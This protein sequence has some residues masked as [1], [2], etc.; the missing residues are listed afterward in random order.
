MGAYSQRLIE[1]RVQ[2]AANQFPLAG[3]AFYQGATLLARSGSDGRFAFLSEKDSLPVRVEFL[4]YKSIE[5]NILPS[6]DFLALGLEP[7]GHSLGEVTISAFNSGKS[8]LDQAGSISVIR[9][10]DLRRDNPVSI[11]N[12]LNRVPGLFMHSGTW[13]THRITIRGI[14]SRSPFGTNK[15][16]AY[17]AEIPLTSGEG[18]TVI[19]DLDLSNLGRVEV[20]RGPASSLYGSGLGGTI[21][22]APRAPVSGEIS[23]EVSGLAGSFG[24]LRSTGRYSS[25]TGRAASDLAYHYTRSEGFRENNQFR[26]YGFATLRQLSTSYGSFTLLMNATHVDALIPSSIDSAS[27]ASDPSAAAPT[28][29]KT[30]GGEDYSRFLL[31]ASYRYEISR[32]WEGASAVFVGFRTAQETRPF[33]FLRESTYWAGGRSYFTWKGPLFGRPLRG[34]LG[35]ELY[36]DW[37]NGSL[38]ANVG[39]TGQRGGILGDNFE[40]R[41]YINAY[42]QAVWELSE[43]SSLSAGLNGNYTYYR[44]QDFFRTDSTNR[45]GRY[46]FQP[47]LSPRL[48]L[49][50]RL[51]ES[52]SLHATLSHGFS[53]PTLAETLT[54][55]GQINPDIQPETG[56]NLEAG[57]RGE[58]AGG[59]LWLDLTA[60]HMPVR[61]LLVAERTQDD[62]LIGR[63]AGRTRHDGLEAALSLRLA[64]AARAQLSLFASYHYARYRFVEFRDDGADYSGNVL[65]GV[66]AHHLSAGLE[67]EAGSFSG[68]ITFQ[69]SGRMP[70]RDDNSLW[71]E[72][73]SLLNA[74]AGW[75]RTLFRRFRLALAAGIQNALDA[76]YASM[77]QVNAPGALP[78]YYY[79]GAPRNYY[80][81]LDL[82]YRYR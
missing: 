32:R 8:L 20:L 81:Q 4:G 16:R 79:P 57:F 15:I 9:P 7:E 31:G 25:A 73:F 64:E 41:N 54:P 17:L 37:H 67:G 10:A 46:D 66:P 18:E 42:A 3:A 61:N 6:Q 51:G 62:L 63:N 28:W 29:L 74:R 21:L 13:S 49:L 80:L 71:T 38:Y 39:G 26:R 77:V 60:Y 82:G 11:T 24:L 65:T 68:N 70:I 76:R 53:P 35:G 2:D 19:E 59:R 30:R 40:R 47:L 44:Y 5:I 45:S 56:W 55:A 52:A 58:L 22:I 43:K 12:A 72:P 1:G 50:R 33:N 14:G 23:G 78:R 75:Q 27:F 69:H 48:S 34:T 36:D